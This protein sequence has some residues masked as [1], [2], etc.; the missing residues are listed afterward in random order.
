M[1]KIKRTPK[2]NIE[3]QDEVRKKIAGNLKICREEKGLSQKETVDCIG[4]TEKYYKEKVE[5]TGKG[6]DNI[7]RIKQ[8]AKSLN[9][10]EHRLL[11]GVF[12]IEKWPA[13]SKD[14]VVAYMKEQPREVL[15]EI[16][17]LII[18]SL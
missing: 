13:I 8:I 6:L 5:K 4:Y 9:V 1:S 3:L 10:P 14:D 15:K 17:C 11:N 2:D 16:L 7:T 12:D 18:G